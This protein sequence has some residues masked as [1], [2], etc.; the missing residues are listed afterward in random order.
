MV[1]GATGN[2]M[3]VSRMLPPF[4]ARVIIANPLQRITSAHTTRQLGPMAG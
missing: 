4:V 3:A 1:I 2:C